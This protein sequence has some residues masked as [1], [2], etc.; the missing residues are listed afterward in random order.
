MQMI[1]PIDVV[2]FL[3][4]ILTG[5]SASALCRIR[6]K[7]GEQA[8]ASVRYRPPPIVFSIAWPILYM[9]TGVSWAIANRQSSYNSIPY[10]LLVVLLTSWIV[11][12]G[13]VG[14]RQASLYVLLLALFASISSAMVG[15]RA[16]RLMIAPLV[17][18]LVFALIMST[19][20]IQYSEN[21]SIYTG[22]L[23]I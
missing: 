13:C 3:I 23:L 6:S 10:T 15:T 16:S 1:R 22:I 18:W 17:G 8:G 4:P 5:Y 9:L 20:E 12:Y 21:F 19:T 14:S 11:V 2:L 7:D